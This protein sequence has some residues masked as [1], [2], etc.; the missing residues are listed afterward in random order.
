AALNLDNVEGGAGFYVATIQNHGPVSA[1]SGAQTVVTQ[2]LG[3]G[4][5]S[6]TPVQLRGAGLGIAGITLDVKGPGGFHVSHGWPIEVR[7]AQLD[8]AREEELPLPAG[9][10]YVAS[11]RVISDL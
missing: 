1:G 6:L 11:R 9:A 5:R 4:Q 7:A 3:H 8:V 10:R 2:T